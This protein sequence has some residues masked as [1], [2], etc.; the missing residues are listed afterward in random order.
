MLKELQELR[1]KME[2]ARS[3]GQMELLY[4]LTCRYLDLYK[5]CYPSH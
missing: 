4:K 2:K 3:E 5:L 1:L